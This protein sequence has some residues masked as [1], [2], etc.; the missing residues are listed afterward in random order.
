MKKLYFTLAIVPILSLCICSPAFAGDGDEG[1]EVNIGI[2]G[3]SEVTVNTGDD[4]EVGVNTGANNNVYLNGQDINE[5]T[6]INHYQSV[7]TNYNMSY[8]RRLTKL[9]YWESN[10][11]GTV[12]II[13]DGLAK[14]II[15][16]EQGK[17]D[18]AELDAQLT[19]LETTI[20]TLDAKSGL[21]KTD[22]NTELSSQRTEY[23]A[24]IDNLNAQ[25]DYLKQVNEWQR[26]T[27]T[28]WIIG[29]VAGMA[30]IGG[31]LYKRTHK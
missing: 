10:T 7:G 25:V 22:I 3:D 8:S 6:V 11:Q 26:V 17:I 21:L 23:L 15:D 2:S 9:E 20:S 30:I 1:M 16:Y 27:V 19:A 14:L 12:Q 13:A 28:W 5:P 24:M 31:L 29:L 18:P 4:S